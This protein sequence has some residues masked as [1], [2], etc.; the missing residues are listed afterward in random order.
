MKNI[1]LKLNIKDKISEHLQQI[2]ANHSDP[3]TLQEIEYRANIWLWPEYYE[4]LIEQ[5]DQPPKVS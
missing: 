5:E 3:I 4:Y 1:V 2:I